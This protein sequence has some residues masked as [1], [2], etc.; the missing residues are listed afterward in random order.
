MTNAVYDRLK[1]LVTG[2]GIQVD[3]NS[4]DDAE[5]YCYCQALDY[6]YQKIKSVADNVFAVSD[7]NIDRY[8]SLLNIDCTDKTYDQIYAEIQ[9]RF[10]AD[11]GDVAVEDMAEDFQIVGSGTYSVS[12]GNLTFENV[13]VED[14]YNLS[15]FLLKWSTP[16][17]QCLFSGNGTTFDV[18]DEW[19]QSFSY[20]DNLQL[21]FSILDTYEKESVTSE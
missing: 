16:Y 2:V 18:W 6:V 3:D 14:L 10:S 15:Q 11:F 20:Y 8:T 17:T 1:A 19:G 13:A 12:R 9:S 21:P 4:V 7:E 5:L